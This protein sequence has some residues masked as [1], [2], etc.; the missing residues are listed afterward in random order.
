MFNF[1]SKITNKILRYFFINQHEKKYINELARI[2]D[3]DPGNLS[4]KLQ[5]LENEGILCSEFLGN[6]RYY[7]INKRYPLLK[8]VKNIFEL[9]CGLADLIAE[10]LKKIKGIKEAYIFGSYVKGNF[11]PESDID[12]LIIGDHSVLEVDRQLIPLQE[13]INREINTIDISKSEFIK[14]K[15][16]KDEFIKNILSKEHIKIL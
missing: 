12:I 2:T 7:Y 8:E 4:R 10:K 5:V 14:R 6:Q 9:K 11:E 3:I 13:K 16:N 15:K 1:N